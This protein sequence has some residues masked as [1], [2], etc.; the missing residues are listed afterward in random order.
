MVALA[1]VPSVAVAVAFLVPDGLPASAPKRLTVGL[2]LEPQLAPEERAARGERL[3]RDLI[4]ALPAA[5]REWSWVQRA[6]AATAPGGDA[7]IGRLRLSFASFDALRTARTATRHWLAATTAA[8]GWME[9]GA[10]PAHAGGERRAEVEVWCS[11]GTAAERRA[12]AARAKARLAAALPSRLIVDGASSQV[13]WRVA[14]RASRVGASGLD[15]DEAIDAALGGF[16]VGAL[17]IAG[18]ET[19]IRLLAS[20]DDE[21]ALVPVRGAGGAAAPVVPLGTAATLR[22]VARSAAVERRDGSPGA[23][24]IV[25]GGAASDL[26]TVRRALAA[27]AVGAG[28][29]LDVV[30]PA[31]EE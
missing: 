4:R 23:R 15:V 20:P 13:E 1:L 31:A 30:G 10:G 3:A 17:Q 28:E 22:R 5:P 11:A 14:P 2:V 9:T 27:V 12:L 16:D 21:L 18:V 7:P 6:P 24:L 26:S 19:G 8:R 29:R 25:L